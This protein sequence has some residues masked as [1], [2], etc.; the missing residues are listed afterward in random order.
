MRALAFPPRGIGGTCFGPARSGLCSA[1]A[2][3][4]TSRARTIPDRPAAAPAPGALGRP[5]DGD[6]DARRA[7]RARRGRQRHGARSRDDRAQRGDAT[8]PELLSREPG[9]MVTNTTTSPEG[10]TVEARGFNDG[11]G[12]GSST[13]VLVDG[14]RLNEAESSTPTGAGCGSTTSSASRSCAGPRARVWGDN[15]VGGVINIITRKGAQGTQHAT[16]SAA[17]GAGIPGTAAASSR[18]AKGPIEVS[19]YADGGTTDDYRQRSD[20]DDHHYEG[21]LRGSARETTSVWGSRPATRAITA[22]APARS[23]RTQI[24]TLGRR[25]ADPA[26]EGDEQQRRRWHVDG[27]GGVDAAR[28]PPL[29]ARSL[30]RRTHAT[31]RC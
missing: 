14:R 15:A 25:A 2:R 24:D 10:Y 1:P 26:T 27:L 5:G 7:R 19:F 17:S 4:R 28:G 29:R 23:R 8:V 30:H 31:T 6:G 9:I 11:G 20:F 18:P 13:L 16:R 12:N 21:S 3:R 22:I